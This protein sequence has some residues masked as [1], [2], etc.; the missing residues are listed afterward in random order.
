M[1]WRIEDSRVGATLFS[2]G[3]EAKLKFCNLKEKKITV[4]ITEMNPPRNES[5]LECILRMCNVA[6]D[7]ISYK[8]QVILLRF[9]FP[10]R[11]S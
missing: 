9:L 11:N 3:M 8:F 5:H 2:G 6:L 1:H 7:H 4:I 10:I